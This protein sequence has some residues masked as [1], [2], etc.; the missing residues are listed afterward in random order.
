MVTS[1]NKVKK[2]DINSIKKSGRSAEGN[3][4][5]KLKDGDY[6]TKAYQ[7]NDNDD[8]ISINDKEIKLYSLSLE[9]TTTTF[10]AFKEK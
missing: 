8:V 7:V 5:G 4:T 9:K 3:V 2:L 6:I 10:K 1:E